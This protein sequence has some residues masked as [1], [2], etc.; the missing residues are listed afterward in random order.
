MPA[1]T[2]DAA[3]PLPDAVKGAMGPAT[4]G[5]DGIGKMMAKGGAPAG[6]EGGSAQGDL[7]TKIDTIKKVMESVIGAST[8]GKTFFSRAVQMMDQGLAAESAKGPGTPA[9]KGPE[10]GAVSGGGSGMGAP[11]SFPG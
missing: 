8:A 11:P 3:P 4:S 7:K 5:F 10:T 2:L 6:P 9:E 1:A